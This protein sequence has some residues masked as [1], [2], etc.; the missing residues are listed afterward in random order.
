MELG[1]HLPAVLITGDTAPQRLR[2]A[3]AVGVPLLHKPVSPVQLYRQ[4]VSVLEDSDPQR[5][6]NQKE[7][8]EVHHDG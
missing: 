3:R 7:G 4:L 2:D 1:I 5:V 8:T 6:A